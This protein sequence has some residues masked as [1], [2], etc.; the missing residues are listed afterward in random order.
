MTNSTENIDD[1][2]AYIES[3]EYLRMVASAQ[4]ERPDSL[5][6]GNPAD[7]Q[8]TP[9]P[10]TAF[11]PDGLAQWERELLDGD[12]VP[13]DPEPMRYSTDP[14]TFGIAWNSTTQQCDCTRCVRARSPRV[15]RPG[16]PM[17]LTT[18]SAAESF[19]YAMGRLRPFKTYGSLRGV[20]RPEAR[21]SGYLSS[22][23]EGAAALWRADYDKID[24][25]VY[26]YNTPIAWHVNGTAVSEWV[27][28]V[29]KYSPTTS[30]HQSKIRTALSYQS[31]N[32]RHIREA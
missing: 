10:R 7:V 15:E 3:P 8:P 4:G 1:L 21:D 26:S 6:A 2:I 12:P 5:L 27:Y 23:N 19:S 11:N 30:A 32:V 14:V 18:R 13:V 17:Q 24:Y 31:D 29:V 25:V 20:V 28:P 22:R 16:S 9:A